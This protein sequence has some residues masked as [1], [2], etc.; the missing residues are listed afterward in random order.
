MA[1]CCTNTGWAV[2]PCNSFCYSCEIDHHLSGELC[3]VK[4]EVYHVLCG[5][6]HLLYHLAL[7]V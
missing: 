1:Y 2:I 6:I 3:I 4:M 5:G 7:H